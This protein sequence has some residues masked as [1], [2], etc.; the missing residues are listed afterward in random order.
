MS[1]KCKR[2]YSIDSPGADLIKE[3]IFVIA[4]ISNNIE[5]S[6]A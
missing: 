5:E 1:G 4:K 3:L 2:K 6:L